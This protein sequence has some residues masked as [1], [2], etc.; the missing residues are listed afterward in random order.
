MRCSFPSMRI[1]WAHQLPSDHLH[2]C[3]CTMEAIADNHSQFFWAHSGLLA[4]NLLERKASGWAMSG[5]AALGPECC[6]SHFGFNKSHKTWTND[7]KIHEKMYLQYSCRQAWSSKF[8]LGFC[9]QDNEITAHVAPILRSWGLVT[10]PPLC[11]SPTAEWRKRSTH[12][13]TA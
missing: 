9:P 7:S 8:G 1:L 11:L 2:Y 5:P 6:L 12:E 3:Q 13:V 4:A 10:P